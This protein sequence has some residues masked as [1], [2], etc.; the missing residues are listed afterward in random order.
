MLLMIIQGTGEHQYVVQVDEAERQIAKDMVH[1][2]LE[3]LS[4]ITEIG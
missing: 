1:F 2:P 4:G 3:G